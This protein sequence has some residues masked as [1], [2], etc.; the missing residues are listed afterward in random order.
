MLKYFLKK[1]LS[2]TMD[3]FV[4]DERLITVLFEAVS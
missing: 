2:Y 3:T 1:H 4:N